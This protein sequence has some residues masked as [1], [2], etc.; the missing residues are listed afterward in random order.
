MFASETVLR[1]FAFV[2]SRARRFVGEG[3]V[4]NAVQP[5]PDYWFGSFRCSAFLA[6]ML[7]VACFPGKSLPAAL[8]AAQAAGI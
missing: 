8:R 6:C 4:M 1:L 5:R 2:F 7:G 3:D